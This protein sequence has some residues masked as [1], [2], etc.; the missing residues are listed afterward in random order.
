MSTLILTLGLIF[1]VYFCSMTNRRLEKISRMLQKEMGLVFLNEGKKFFGN[2][3]ISVTQVIVSPDLGYA[4]FYLNYLNSPD[5]QKVTDLVNFY[6]KELRL[7]L[8]HRIRNQV[9]KIP[10]IAFFYDNSL[11]YYEKIDEIIKK[12]N[13][14]EDN[15]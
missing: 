15:S 14:Q 1:I 12:I 2:V 9:R 4:K 6:E 3:M 5:N 7:A 11:D 8:G 10:E 13:Q